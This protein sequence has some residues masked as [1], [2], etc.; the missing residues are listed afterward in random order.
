MRPLANTRFIF[1]STLSIPL[2]VITVTMNECIK[3][4]IGQLAA[5]A[6]V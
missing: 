2:G 6:P 3:K 1:N 4:A 5:A